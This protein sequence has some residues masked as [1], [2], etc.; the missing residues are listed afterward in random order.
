MSLKCTFPDDL[1]LRG[2]EV[3]M[4]PIE[5]ARDGIAVIE[6]VVLKRALGDFDMDKCNPRGTLK[7]RRAGK[8]SQR[9]DG[10]HM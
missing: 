10:G 3:K 1:T 2:H 5:P 9:S 7:S 8:T 6:Y 4:Y